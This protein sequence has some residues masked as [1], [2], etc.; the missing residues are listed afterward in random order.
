MDA[1]FVPD[2][3]RFAPTEL[4]R[5][6]WSPLHQH[7]GAP[8]ALLA[9]AIERMEPIS[10]PFVTRLTIDLIRPVPLEPLTV[11]TRM[12]RPGRNVQLVEAVLRAGDTEVALCRG[13]RLRVTELDI[14]ATTAERRADILGPDEAPPFPLHR[15]GEPGFGMAMELRL[16]LGGWDEPGPAAV[17]FRLRV[18]LVAGEEPTPLQRVAAAA[19]FGNGVS[20]DFDGG[21]SFINPDLTVVLHRAAEGEWVGLDAITFPEPHGVGVAE[22]ALMDERGRIGRSTQTLLLSPFN[23]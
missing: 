12:R 14:P 2:G 6:P 21:F 8:S 22:S 20:S 3:D 4:A 1:V 9:R 19:D 10:A 18:P 13:L 5:G 23:A 16:G 11:E 15:P 17:W 7:G